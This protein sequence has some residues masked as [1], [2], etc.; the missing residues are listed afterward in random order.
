MALGTRLV[1][2]ITTISA[3]GF[4][5]AKGLLADADYALRWRRN[6]AMM[7]E[8]GTV[9]L[10][11]HVHLRLCYSSTHIQLLGAHTFIFSGCAWCMKVGLYL[12]VFGMAFFER[13]TQILACRP[14]DV[15]FLCVCAFARLSAHIYENERP[16][17]VR[18][19]SKNFCVCVEV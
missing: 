11:I 13:R 2:N 18:A 9:Y 5:T 16:A 4:R 7:K 6:L 19:H 17:R 3:P 15:H 1:G 12:A 14:R 8:I 10:F